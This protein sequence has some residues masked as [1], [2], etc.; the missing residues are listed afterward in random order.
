MSMLSLATLTRP[1]SDFI[2]SQWHYSYELGFVRRGLWGSA[3]DLVSD[4]SFTAVVTAS[5]VLYLAATIMLIVALEQQV[6]EGRGIDP[7]RAVLATALLGSAAG[8]PF[9]VSHL[10]RFDTPTILLTVAAVLVVHRSSGAAGVLVSSLLL[11][12]AVLGHEAA[13]LTTVPW[14]AAWISTRAGQIRGRLAG[15]LS[16]AAVLGLPILA[17][18]ALREPP[19]SRSSFA[20]WLSTRV[21]RPLTDQHFDVV[22]PFQAPSEGFRAAVE[23][24]LTTQGR[25]FMAV[26]V[27]QVMPLLSGCVVALQD[28]GVRWRQLDRHEQTLYAL[29]L[30]PV[31][32]CAVTLDFSRW[33]AFAGLLVV[34]TTLHVLSKRGCRVPVSGA[35]RLVAALTIIAMLTGAVIERTASR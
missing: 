35:M 24:L 22:V 29:A 4:V 10:G 18:M 26:A 28:S 19:M 9:L 15:R 5:T 8:F 11:V 33:W 17:F 6:A 30:L 14:A 34:A 16:A 7:T 31:G 12:G 25:I 32:L 27:L 20:T 21:G 13:L 1:I 3:L 2:T 23:L